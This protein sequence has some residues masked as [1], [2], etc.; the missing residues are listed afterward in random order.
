MS[1][2]LA[3]VICAATCA[4]QQ[5]SVYDGDTFRVGKESIRVLH[6]DAPEIKGR[7]AAERRMAQ[8][9]KGELIRILASGKLTITRDGT[10]RYGRSLATIDVGGLDVGGQMIESGAARPWRGHRENWCIE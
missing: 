2:I 10:D 7:C 3:V 9:S 8:A 5:I 6:I 1:T 4:P